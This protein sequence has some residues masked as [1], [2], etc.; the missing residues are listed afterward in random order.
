MCSVPVNDPGVCGW[1]L[2]ASTDTWL[3]LGPCPF[4]PKCFQFLSTCLMWLTPCFYL[5]SWSCY[6]CQ[7]KWKRQLQ[8]SWTFLASPPF[9][10]FGEE[11]VERR[12]EIVSKSNTWMKFAAMC[13]SR[14]LLLVSVVFCFPVSVY[15]CCSLSVEEVISLISVRKLD[16]LKQCVAVVGSMWLYWFIEPVSCN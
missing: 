2:V 1:L 15:F 8:T 10:S 9:W 4:S 11:A 5:W 12:H 13:K 16:S 7:V 3:D 6:T 14:I